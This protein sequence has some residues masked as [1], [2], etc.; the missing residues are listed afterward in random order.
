LLASPVF[1]AQTPGAAALPPPGGV[2]L[3][4][5]VVHNTDTN[6][7]NTDTF[8]D[9]ENSIAVNPANPD[10]I[11]ISG[12]SGCWANCGTTNAP[13][14]HSTD[15]G[16]TWTKRFSI[17]PPPGLPNAGC[18]CDQTFDFD[19]PGNL[20]GSFLIPNHI[21]TGSTDD[22][23]DPARWQWNGNPVQVTDQSGTTAPDQNWLMVNRSPTNAAVDNVYVGYDDFALFP[24][25]TRVAVSSNS[26]PPNFTIDTD[27]GDASTTGATNPG[28]RLAGDPT[29]GHMYLIYQQGDQNGMSWRLNRST[30]GGLT[31]SLNGDP[32]GIIVGSGP[33]RQGGVDAMKFGDVNALLGGVDQLAVD[34]ITGD[35]MVVF[36]T[37]SSPGTTNGNHLFVR[38]ILN[39][40]GDTM[41]PQAPVQITTAENAALPAIAVASD[42]TVGVFYY[43]FDNFDSNGFA[44]FST[45]FARS[46]N[47]AAP[48]NTLLLQT[49][50]APVK[51]DGTDGQRIFFDY[52]Q[53]RAVGQV[54]YGAYT[55]GGEQFG[56]PDTPNSTVELDPIFFAVATGQ[57]MVCP[58]GLAPTLSGTPGNDNLVGTA[59]DDVIFG[60]GGNDKITGLGGNDTICGG[61]GNDDLYGVDGNDKLFGD[62][63]ADRLTGG[64][65]NDFLAGG[66][67]APDQASGGPG[68]DVIDLIDAAGGDQASG[69]PHVTGDVCAGD[70]G[71]TILSDCNP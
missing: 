30:D 63:G 1:I 39:D 31:W 38:R 67:G 16:V 48:F 29:T 7:R 61:D 5:A 58:V 54:F 66:I 26:T 57:P 36:G 14:F 45:H 55:G 47:G 10:E 49:F 34:P 52:D 46:P 70:P 65:G 33:S 8:G 2:L 11:V 23:A 24:R 9:G 18:P 6:L 15:G 43:T 21:V 50:T 44:V 4:D 28:L 60:L 69:G 3:R 27:A 25:D 64:N 42:G 12:F 22:P 13:L 41:T 35:V 62:A 20:F 56:H 53:L 59:G 19:R 51:D 71:D 68:D 37:S 40:A 17:P 32:N